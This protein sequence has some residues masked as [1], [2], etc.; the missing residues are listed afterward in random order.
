[1]VNMLVNIDRLYSN[2]PISGSIALTLNIISVLLV[3]FCWE[4]NNDRITCL[5]PYLFNPDGIG[6]KSYK[7]WRIVIDILNCDSDVGNVWSLW[8]AIVDCMNNHMITEE[9]EKEEGK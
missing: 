9:K 2:M 8:V 6:R 5:L 1:M 7:Y 4:K 3:E